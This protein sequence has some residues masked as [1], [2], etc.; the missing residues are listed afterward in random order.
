VSRKEPS[1]LVAA[2]PIEE[3]APAKVNLTLSVLGK[4]NDGYHEL[5]SLVAFADIGDR[6]RLEPS[7]RWS[8]TCEGP[9]AAAISGPNSVDLAARAFAQHWPAA[10][11]GRGVLHKML[12]V[13]AGIGGGSSDAAAVLRAL[14]RLNPGVAAIDEPIWQTLARGLG[15]D[16]PVCLAGRMAFMQGTGERLRP[17][18]RKHAL[19]AVLVN[20]GV[21][22][23]T[24]SVFENLDAVPWIEDQAKAGPAE[25]DDS[26]GLLD[27]VRSGRNDLEAPALKLAPAIGEVLDALRANSACWLA[28]MSG[29]GPT[30]FGLFGT[31]AQAQAAATLLAAKAPNW[32]V[33]ST[34]LG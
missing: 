28:R 4:R 18:V 23:A 29:S 34:V 3:L 22:L 17:L 33:R 20:P 30:C 12:P 32:W 31:F 27:V 26:A 24:R 15:A 19:P 14:R 2:M 25:P 11:T 9:M 5:E 16:V 13:F 7:D 10:R 21:T 1:P 6:V 8:L